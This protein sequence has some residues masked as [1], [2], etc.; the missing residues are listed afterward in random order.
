MELKMNKFLQIIKR[1]WYLLALLI[2]VPSIVGGIIGC[3]LYGFN[4]QGEGLGFLIFGLSILPI[5]ISI[6]KALHWIAFG[7]LK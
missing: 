4:F 2:A 6:H 1:A 7:T 3:V 5:A